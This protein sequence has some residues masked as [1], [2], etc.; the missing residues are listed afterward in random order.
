MK[1]STIIPAYNAEKHIVRAIDSVLA[2]TRPADEIIVIDDGSTDN[3]AG[4][5][6]SYG[7][8]VKLIQQPNAGASVA[9]NTGIEAAAGD[10]IA[11]LDA[12]DEWLEGCLQKHG[13]L[14]ERNPHLQWTSGNF[15]LCHCDQNHH[16][17]E[18]LP[19]QK[20][21]ELL[22]GKDF[23]EDY[24]QAFIAGATGCTDTL[25]IQK[26]ALIHTGLFTPG[27]P[28]ANDLDMWWR[29]AYQYPEIGYCPEPLA[30]YHLH[31]SDS[32]TKVHRDPQILSDF[33]E[34]HIRLSKEN[35]S[36]DR[37]HPCLEHMLRF[38]LHKYLHDDRIAAVRKMVLRFQSYLPSGYVF[39][40]KCLTVCPAATTF[41]LPKLRKI[42]RIIRLKA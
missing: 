33:L 11:F 32:I 35:K 20:G 29:I 22:A 18:K 26:K 25:M 12:D 38:W 21:T 42:N 3:T 1:I 14:L 13:D 36:F 17:Q 7:D 19:V 2:Q 5:V 4:I 40:M 41:L 10:W 24:F 8:K 34:K 27:Q 37:F 39:L 6:R 30:V 15:W 31:V 28:M 16:R 23:F 9:R